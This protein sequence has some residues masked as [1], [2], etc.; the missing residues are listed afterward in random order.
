LL[1]LVALSAFAAPTRPDSTILPPAKVELDTLVRLPRGTVLF[2]KKAAFAKIKDCVQIYEYMAADSMRKAGYTTMSDKGEAMISAGIWEFRF[3]KDSCL[4]EP[5]IVRSPIPD[6]VMYR[7]GKV[8]LWSLNADGTWG[9]RTN[10]IKVTRF[11]GKPYYEFQ[12]KGSTKMT[13][14]LCLDCKNSVRQVI[15]KKGLKIVDIRIS[16]TSPR[17]IFVPAPK[18]SKSGKL[19][20]DEFEVCLPCPEVE[21]QICAKAISRKGDTLIMAYRPIN[22]L[23]RKDP[24]PKCNSSKKTKKNADPKAKNDEEEAD[25]YDRYFLYPK[26]F[27]EVRPK[28]KAKKK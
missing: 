7:R 20:K 27:A 14:G 11:E 1:S 23:E 18:K 26:D 3:C 24:A 22:E 2:L 28:A 17:G 19:S 25:L 16:Y 9:S 21:P 10:G 6:E 13:G 5:I 4:T 8:Q 15:A 12:T